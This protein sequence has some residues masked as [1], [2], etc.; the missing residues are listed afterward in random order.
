MITKEQVLNAITDDN[1]TVRKYAMDYF[2]VNE[3]ADVQVTNQIL[4]ALDNT[5][6][7]FEMIDYL[8]KIRNANMNEK[9][10]ERMSGKYYFDSELDLLVNGII[11]FAD[12]ELLS[13]RNDIRPKIEVFKNRVKERREYYNTDFDELWKL[14]WEIDFMHPE[15]E[16]MV[17]ILKILSERKDFNYEKFHDEI[18]I[19]ALIGNE[20]AKDCDICELAGYLKD[21]YMIDYLFSKLYYAED[22][23]SEV[24]AKSLAKIGTEKVVINI[25]ENYSEMPYNIKMSFVT[26]LEEIKIEKSEKLLLKLYKTEENETLKSLMLS[27]LVRHFSKDIIPYLFEEVATNINYDAI[28]W[29]YVIHKVNKIAHPKL[30]EWEENVLEKEELIRKIR[31]DDYNQENFSQ[32]K[33]ITFENDNKKIGRNDPC[34]CG[35]GKKYKKCCMNK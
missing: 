6:D 1:K 16:N 24:A 29:L 27:G 4:D 9:T 14:Y 15:F 13:K 34:P 2:C 20:N 33:A 3:M 22:Y 11:A 8:S 21:E 12:V 30:K 19:P 10:L 25:K 35:S 26:L 31:L 7:R 17:I 5:D 23:V 32:V 18:D 28:E